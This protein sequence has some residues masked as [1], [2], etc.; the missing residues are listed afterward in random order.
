[1]GSGRCA[2]LP[3]EHSLYWWCERGLQHHYNLILKSSKSSDN[4]T[5]DSKLTVHLKTAQNMMLP[6]KNT[7]FG[8]KGAESG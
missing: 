7:L 1:M 3:T 2:S 8:Q 5:E 6:L 4:F